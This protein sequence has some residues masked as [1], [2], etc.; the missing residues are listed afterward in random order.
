MPV[1]Y[2]VTV[3]SAGLFTMLAL[4]PRRRP[5]MLAYLSF[6]SAAVFNEL[7]FLVLAYVLASTLIAAGQGDLQGAGGGACAGVAVLTA[8]GL[9]VVA[10]RATQ[11]RRAMDC[12]LSDGLGDPWRSQLPPPVLC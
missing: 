1:G 7:P 10:W 12:A 9:G 11:T 2:L 8:G 3:V 5:R 4:A 6:L